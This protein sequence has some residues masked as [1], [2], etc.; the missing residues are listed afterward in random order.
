MSGGMK[1]NVMMKNVLLF[2]NEFGMGF[3]PDNNAEIM[4]SLYKGQNSCKWLRLGAFYA[5]QKWGPFDL[6]LKQKRRNVKLPKLRRIL[7][8]SCT[9]FTTTTTTTS[10][11][12]TP[13]TPSIATA[14]LIVASNGIVAS[15]VVT[16]QQ[17]DIEPPVVAANVVAVQ[18]PN[19]EP[20]VVAVNVVA[21]QQPNV[22]PPV[23]MAN[24]VAVPNVEPPAIEE[25]NN[26]TNEDDGLLE[27]KKFV[28]DM[29]QN[30]VFPLI[31]KD[32]YLHG[33][34]WK[35]TDSFGDGLTDELFSI[36]KI[37]LNRRAARMSKAI[38]RADMSPKPQLSLTTFE[39]YGILPTNLVTL[40]GIVRDLIKLDEVSTKNDLFS[41]PMAN[42][43]K[44]SLVR[45]PQ[46]S[47][48]ERIQRNDRGSTQWSHKLI[49]Q[50]HR[51]KAEQRVSKNPRRRV[52]YM[53]THDDAAYNEEQDD[54]ESEPVDFKEEDEVSEDELAASK[55]L[56]HIGRKFPKSFSLAADELTITACQPMNAVST[57]AMWSAAN[58]SLPQTRSVATH[59][60]FHFGKPLV[61]PEVNIKR[62]LLDNVKIV[63]PQCH[64][65]DNANEKIQWMIRDITEIV[66]AYLS[67]LMN[68]QST[69]RQYHSVDV[70]V[71]ID[72]GKGFSRALIVVIGRWVDEAGVFHE[73]T[74]V[75]PVAEA[76]CASDTYEILVGTYMKELDKGLWRLRNGKAAS[77][78]DRGIGMPST[79]DDDSDDFPTV[80]RFFVTLS[81][82]ANAEVTTAVP[83]YMEATINVMASGD[84]KQLMTN[85][86]RAN[87][88]G[89]WCLWCDLSK[90][91]WKEADHQIGV[92]WNHETL[93][94]HL[95]STKDST[96][97]DVIRGVKDEI[98]LTSVDIDMIT[99]PILHCQLG[100]MNFGMKSCLLEVQA[101]AETYSPKYL[102]LE[103]MYNKAI[104]LSAQSL[105]NIR[106]A[107]CNLLH[108]KY[109][110]KRFAVTREKK[111]C[112]KKDVGICC[113]HQ[114]NCLIVLL[115]LV[116]KKSEGN[117]LHNS[118]R[119]KKN[120]PQRLQHQKI[121]KPMGN[122]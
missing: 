121:A 110:L 32:T 79:S 39:K 60:R 7:R 95:E 28:R 62:Q 93:R 61:C 96:T 3:G 13:S 19:V 82:E 102:L 2:F 1:Q 75:F 76:K 43:K 11:N 35:S 12:Q 69:R 70:I 27:D 40:E 119:Q 117:P 57:F 115:W 15:N 92:L 66:L 9:I 46:S 54:R 31:F 44:V 58:M 73:I 84:L 52:L 94:S 16:V 56:I 86:G 88:S 112:S 83:L 77:V 10:T 48:I 38:G 67:S 80:D 20:P 5:K 113:R 50:F 51:T 63:E 72:H 59:L 87:Y 34:F 111:R 23:V 8:D 85:V 116:L 106:T 107:E 89:D 6:A 97:A 91:E 101:A 17:S 98:I 24:V 65:Y 68:R 25:P 53:T 29:L 26:S 37:L 103:H 49:R 22:E 45:I 100:L 108:Q 21:M 18:Q 74:E 14:S 104:Q 4:P 81:A 42:G 105:D 36:T 78:W 120:S 90:K 64:T 41:V 99:L 118:E 33:D 109:I 47:D 55:L 30:H 114:S 122:R 71:S